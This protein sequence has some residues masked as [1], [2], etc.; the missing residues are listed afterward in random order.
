MQRVHICRDGKRHTVR[1]VSQ[2][3]Y[4]HKGVS[5]V[6]GNVLDAKATTVTRAIRTR[7]EL[8]G[9]TAIYNSYQDPQCETHQDGSPFQQLSTDLPTYINARSSSPS[10][11]PQPPWI[12]LLARNF[13]H[14]RK[15]SSS[16]KT[17]VLTGMTNVKV[18]TYPFPT[19]PHGAPSTCVKRA[20][21]QMEFTLVTYDE[22]SW[23]KRLTARALPHRAVPW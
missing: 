19:S 4:N 12:L 20:D 17:Q 21:N 7:L 15:I 23:C 9:N 5:M 16:S 14:I 2:T 22:I 18:A 6:N 10:S 13:Y 3:K 1:Q 8:H 11:A